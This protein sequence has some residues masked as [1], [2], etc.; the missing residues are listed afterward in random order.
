MNTVTTYPMT[1]S[2]IRVWE[3]VD[4]IW[5]CWEGSGQNLF[6][7]Q[8]HDMQHSLEKSVVHEGKKRAAEHGRP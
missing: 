8:K 3:E 6:L 7:N 5:E 1:A 2:S 4:F